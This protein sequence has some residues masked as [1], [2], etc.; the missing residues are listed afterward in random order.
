MKLWQAILIG[1]DRREQAFGNFFENNDQGQCKSCALGAA[2]EATFD[3]TDI[4]SSGTADMKLCLKYPIL[5]KELDI[6]GGTVMINIVHLNDHMKW[7]RERIALEFVK[8][9]E[10]K[11]EFDEG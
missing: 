9:L 4:I 8:P 5:N 6:K 2:Y 11:E 7:T 3:S 1:S 10:D